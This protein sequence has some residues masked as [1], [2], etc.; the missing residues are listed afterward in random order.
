MFNLSLT[1]T[2]LFLMVAG[3]ILMSFLVITRSAICMILD[4]QRLDAR[5][6]S[7]RGKGQ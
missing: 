5:I 3:I 7:L 1:D 2:T 6:Y 4:E